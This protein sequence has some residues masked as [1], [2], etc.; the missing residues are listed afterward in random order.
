MIHYLKAFSSLGLVCL[1]AAAGFVEGKG[2]GW[3]WGK[4]DQVG[5]LNAMTDATRLAAL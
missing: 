4:E 5:S 1:I 2:Y 3:I